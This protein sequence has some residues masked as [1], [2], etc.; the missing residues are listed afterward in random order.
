MINFDEFD[1]DETDIIPDKDFKDFLKDNDVYND[2]VNTLKN[3]YMN[4]GE[5][6]DLADKKSYISRAFPWDESSRGAKFWVNIN[7]KWLNYLRQK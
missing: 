3:G 7:R 4:I 1:I 6:F 5:F 2:Y